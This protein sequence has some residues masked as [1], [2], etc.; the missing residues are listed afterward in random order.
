MIIFGL[1]YY[2]SAII[3]TLYIG[4]KIHEN[5]IKSIPEYFYK[6]LGNIP[7]LIAS[8][9]IPILKSYKLLCIVSSIQTSFFIETYIYVNTIFYLNLRLLSCIKFYNIYFKICKLWFI[10]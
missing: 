8:I 1:F 3:F 7:G 5:N 6:Y 9:L 4:P 10:K 2:I